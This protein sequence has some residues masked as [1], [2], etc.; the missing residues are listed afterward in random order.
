[1]ASRISKRFAALAEAGRSGLV[2][3]ITAGDPSPEATV[4]IMHALVRG[5][6][7]VIELGVPFSDPMADG[8][9]IQR[10]SE[11]ALAAGMSL[12]RV[13]DIARAFRATDTDTPLVLMGYLNPIE[14]MGYANFVER[15]AAAGVDGILTVDL[16]PEEAAEFH[17]LMLARGLD[18]IHLLAPTSSAERMEAVCRYATGFVY[19]VSVKGVTGDKV[20]DADEVR[21]RIAQL[22]QKTALPIGVGF[23]VKTPATAAAVAA[24]SDAVIVG[25]ALVEIIE[26]AGA[27]AAS[28]L[29]QY[30]RSLR[31]AM[32]AGRNAA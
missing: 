17:R 6:A 21:A 10:A 29:E 28:A 31:T 15:A 12:K 7:D 19:Y 9:I 32:D 11:R 4:P 27:A 5:G 18:Q 25:S 30:V 20:L 13:L 16:P 3:F 1:M 2:T 26:Q 8:P 22:K 24:V 23:G 14:R